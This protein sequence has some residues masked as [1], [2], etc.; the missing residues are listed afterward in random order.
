MLS[1]RQLV[2]R[3]MRTHRGKDWEAVLLL[4]T[5][6]MFKVAHGP[7]DLTEDDTRYLWNFVQNMVEIR[8]REQMHIADWFYV[9]AKLGLLEDR[10]LLR[11]V[12]AKVSTFKHKGLDFPSAAHFAQ[13]VDEPPTATPEP[14]LQLSAASQALVER[15]VAAP[16][17]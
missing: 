16:T 4:L 9:L 7:L 8:P 10:T 11:D 1:F 12:V 17:G 6:H 3:A 14:P 2:D 13:Y 15:A 5:D